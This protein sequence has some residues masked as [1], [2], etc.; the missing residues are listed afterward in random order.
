MLRMYTRV[1]VFL[2][3]VPLIVPPNEKE[4]VMRERV[5]EKALTK[6]VRK[7]GGIA[8]KFISPG[9]DG[10][11]DRL[12]LMK[13]GR[14]AFVELKSPGKK[15]RPLQEKRKAQIEAL[16]FKVFVIAYT[17]MIG[18]VLDEIQST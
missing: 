12:V 18:A 9:M 17:E 7:R 10:V 14:I 6:E 3:I 8:F 1:R 13:D 4:G 5:V 16:G 15:L 2:S 11:P